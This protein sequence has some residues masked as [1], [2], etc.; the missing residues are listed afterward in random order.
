MIFCTQ[1]LL[2][3]NACVEAFSLGTLKS[4]N[5][6]GKTISSQVPQEESESDG[7]ASDDD[8]MSDVMEEEE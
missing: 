3:K 1:N 6:M 8:V 7:D 5:M 2:V 4:K